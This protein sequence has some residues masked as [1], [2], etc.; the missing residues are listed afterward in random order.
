M[1][2]L[3]KIRKR[4]DGE[5]GQSLAEFALLLPVLLILL[6]G[7][8]EVGWGLNSY[9]T[10][11]DSARDGARLGSKGSATDAEITAL[12]VREAERLNGGVNPSNVSIVR[13]TA[14]DGSSSIDVQVCYDHALIMGVPMI[15]PNPLQM[16]S[17]TTMPTLGN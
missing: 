2:S 6:V 3:F 11:V 5:K 13:S 1:L 9:L 10:V 8:V 14:L 16:C 4:V 7:I 12:V 17:S 15:V